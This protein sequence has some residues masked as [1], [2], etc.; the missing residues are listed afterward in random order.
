MKCPLCK[1][2]MVEEDFG[3]VKVDV[4]VIGCRGMWFD[5]FELSQLDDKHEGFGNALKEA[6]DYPRVKDER[7]GEINCPKC[8]I[9]ML[10]H[11]YESAKEVNVDECYGCGGI[12]LDSGELKVIRDTHM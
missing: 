10:R 8:G 2:E 11:K 7:R 1:K 4:C 5:W 12:F 9:P 6:L 3:G